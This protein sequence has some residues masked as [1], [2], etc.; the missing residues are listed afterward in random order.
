MPDQYEKPPWPEHG[1]TKKMYSEWLDDIW[2]WLNDHRIVD[3][4]NGALVCAPGGGYLIDPGFV[5]DLSGLETW[6]LQGYPSP[7]LGGG[8]PPDDQPRRVRVR[9]GSVNSLFPTN[10]NSE[11]LCPDGQTTIFWI[12]A[13]FDG[14]ALFLG[15][16]IGFGAVVPDE[17]TG[18]PDAPPAHSYRPI[19]Q[20]VTLDNAIT[21]IVPI[22]K[23]SLDVHA[24]VSNID[25]E[26]NTVEYQWT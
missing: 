24:V 6:P 7:Y 15:S 13:N 16:E 14:S 26:Q 2:I 20:V 9:V 23:T 21:S 12:Q 18:G 25:C 19:F 1:F 8:D 10:I 11:F 22:R 17:P 5:Q 3:V 4:L